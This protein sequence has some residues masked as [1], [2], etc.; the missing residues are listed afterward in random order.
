MFVQYVGSSSALGYIRW[1]VSINHQ[2]L[3]RLL[4]LIGMY[5]YQQRIISLVESIEAVFCCTKIKIQYKI[6]N[7]IFSVRHTLAQLF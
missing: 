1:H 7:N 2:T 4:V 5:C 6:H 3:Q